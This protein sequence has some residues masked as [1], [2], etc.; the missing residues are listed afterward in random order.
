MVFCI[1]SCEPPYRF[2]IL[3]GFVRI[4]DTVCMTTQGLLMNLQFQHRHSTSYQLGPKVELSSASHMLCVDSF[5]GLCGNMRFPK[6]PSEDSCP[7]AI[8][9]WYWV[10]AGRGAHWRSNSDGQTE[11]C[12][13][14]WWV[15]HVQTIIVEWGLG[16]SVTALC[17]GWNAVGM[18]RLTEERSSWRPHSFTIWHSSTL[19]VIV[20]HIIVNLA[21]ISQDHGIPSCIVCQPLGDTLTS[22]VV[23]SRPIKLG[24]SRHSVSLRLWRT[25][26]FL[27]SRRFGRIDYDEWRMNDVPYVSSELWAALLWDESQLCPWLC[28]MLETWIKHIWTWVEEQRDKQIS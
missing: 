16:V 26:V 23:R 20:C 27:G 5:S 3:H 25:H 14:S 9:M 10:R 28:W 19:S 22:L 17:H 24:A 1:V 6:A 11:A 15:R 7:F 8:F 4:W 12:M 2:D 21:Q 13:Q 18:L